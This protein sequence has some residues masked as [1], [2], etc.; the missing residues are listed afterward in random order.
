[1][2]YYQILII[3]QLVITFGCSNLNKSENEKIVDE[4]IGKE[5]IL[6]KLKYND[7]IKENQ[8]GLKIVSRINGNCY[9]CISQLTEWKEFMNS[10]SQNEKFPFY[11]Y[12][13]IADSSVYNKINKEKIHFDYPVIFDTNDDFRKKN[14]LSH[15]NIFHSMLIDSDN[16]VILIGNPISNVTMQDLYKKVIDN[17]YEKN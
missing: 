8:S 2:K 14:K 15:N 4:W 12:L 11:F 3:I 10:F 9:S 16:K 17:Y 7:I 6:P 1:M 13:V 5:I